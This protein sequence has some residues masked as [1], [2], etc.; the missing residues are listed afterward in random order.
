MT[1]RGVAPHVGWTIPSLQIKVPSLPFEGLAQR[2]GGV[3]FI[4]ADLR[5]DMVGRGP[6]GI[7]LVAYDAS[8]I[9]LWA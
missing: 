5:V 8:C 9:V 3:I 4:S 2:G 1:L 6:Y 7:V